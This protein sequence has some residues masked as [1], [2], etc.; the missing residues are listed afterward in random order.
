MEFPNSLYAYQH[1][2]AMHGTIAGTR[3]LF[4][5]GNQDEQYLSSVL[6]P[7]NYLQLERTFYIM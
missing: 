5:C 7:T 1:A 6:K 2:I 4:A 3:E